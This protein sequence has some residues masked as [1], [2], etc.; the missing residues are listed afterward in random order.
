MFI[1]VDF[2]SAQSAFPHY[3]RSNPFSSRIG[4]TVKVQIQ[5][6]SLRDKIPLSATGSEQGSSK[7]DS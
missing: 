2:V 1:S 6:E 3:L 7:Q 5:A 4:F